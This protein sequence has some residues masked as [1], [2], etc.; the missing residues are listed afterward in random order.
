[1]ENLSN[2]NWENIG[3]KD[4]RSGFGDAIYELGK[5]R[6]NVVALCADL[7]GSLKL[8]KFADEFP[9]RFFQIGIAF[10]LRVVLSF[11]TEYDNRYL[12]NRHR[13][14]LQNKIEV[15]L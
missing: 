2:L 9:N 13:S 4:T 10:K 11:N 6:E 7:T 3:S 15:L 12:L 5:E 8:E 14:A 1:M